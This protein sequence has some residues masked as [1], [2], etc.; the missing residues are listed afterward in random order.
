MGCDITTAAGTLVGAKTEREEHASRG[1]VF[2]VNPRRAGQRQH[3][4]TDSMNSGVNTISSHTG[5]GERPLISPHQGPCQGP[6]QG[7]RMVAVGGPA[8]CPSGSIHLTHSSCSR[9]CLSG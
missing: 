7:D 4:Y 6:C 8:V 5:P 1:G 3:V 9:S 2:R